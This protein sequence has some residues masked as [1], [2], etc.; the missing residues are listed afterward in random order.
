LRACALHPLYGHLSFISKQLRDCVWKELLEDA[1]EMTTQSMLPQEAKRISLSAQLQSLRGLFESVA[2]QQRVKMIRNFNVF[3]E[4]KLLGNDF[5]GLFQVMQGYACLQGATH[6]VER[7]WSGVGINS[8]TGRALLSEDHVADL[9]VARD[10]LLNE[11]SCGVPASK[12][13]GDLVASIPATTK[14]SSA[15]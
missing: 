8:N 12:I 2:Y 10:F 7:M 6:E 14:G 5:A 4:Y 1:V 13:A 15:S 9:A 3:N 11:L